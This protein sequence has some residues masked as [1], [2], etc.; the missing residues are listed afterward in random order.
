M[1]SLQRFVEAARGDLFVLEQC[2]SRVD[3]HASGH[4]GRHRVG[5]PRQFVAQPL[6]AL[7]RARG[8]RAGGGERIHGQPAVAAVRQG[9]EH[10]AAVRRE[11]QFLEAFGPFVWRPAQAAQ[12]GGEFVDAGL[13]GGLQGDE[14]T[15]GIDV[16]PT[17]VAGGQPQLANGPA[18]GH[19]D[20]PRGGVVREGDD[21][22]AVGGET[23]IERKRRVLDDLLGP[24]R[25]DRPEGR[26]VACPIRGEHERAVVVDV[27]VLGASL[28]TIEHQRTRPQVEGLHPRAGETDQMRAGRVAARTQEVATA[29]EQGL[30]VG[31]LQHHRLRGPID[32]HRV[33][34][35]SQ[36]G[37]GLVALDLA[38]R[39]HVDAADD[40]DQRVARALAFPAPAQ[41]QV[42][43]RDRQCPLQGAARECVGEAPFLAEYGRA[44]LVGGTVVAEGIDPLAVV[45]HRGAVECVA[46]T[47]HRGE[48]Q[49][50]NRVVDAQQWLVVRLA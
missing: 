33:L 13:F 24:V 32:D 5:R 12:A 44:P 35:R 22:L 15:A 17:E 48:M 27:H 43:R 47:A 1:Q 29:A 2:D 41:R 42:A 40:V 10:L 20:D 23:R 3:V 16:N 50:Q 25:G 21:V 11:R 19:V 38:E 9:R 26:R 49:P 37:F 46:S 14:P 7:Q 18:G 31:Q 8:E 39:G 6:V 30:P 28:F 45:R 34:A 4:L 36:A